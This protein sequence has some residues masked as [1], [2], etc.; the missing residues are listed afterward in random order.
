MEQLPGGA[1]GLLILLMGLGCPVGF[2]FMLRLTIAGFRTGEIRYRGK[3]YR[4]SES[5]LDY[6][7]SMLLFC[8]VTVTVGVIALIFIFLSAAMI[9]P[10]LG[11]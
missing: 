3:F 2:I 1:L 6:W 11:R 9:V 5:A 8:L 4:K 7:T 10:L